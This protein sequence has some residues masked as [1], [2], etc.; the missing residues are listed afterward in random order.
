MMVGFGQVVCLPTKP[1][2]FE[3]KNKDICPYAKENPDRTNK[4]ASQSS[5]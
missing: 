5:R 4:K 2:C 3:C 1:R